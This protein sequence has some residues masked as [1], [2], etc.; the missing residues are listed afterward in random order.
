MIKDINKILLAVFLII[1]GV[2]SRTAWHLGPN[3]EFVTAS[4]LLAGVY[5]GL[6]YSLLVPLIIMVITD[7]IIG[8]TNIFLFTWSAYLVIGYLGNLG[9][10]SNL[11]FGPR[12]LRATGLG[13]IASFW[14]FLWTNFGVWFLDSWGMYE[15]NF[16]GLLQAYIMGL[17]FM[18]YN[19]LGNIVLVPSAFFLTEFGKSLV[20]AN[21][22][23]YIKI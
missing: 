3:I 11:K 18:K 13:V 16:S 14:F 5:L 7:L 10:L 2:L 21:L 6:N 12:M 4:S 9:H 23:K 8:N 15:R 20:E 19:L 1:L 22:R 17:P